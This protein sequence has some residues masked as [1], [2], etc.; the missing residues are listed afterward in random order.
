MRELVGQVDVVADD[1]ELADQ[2]TADV[3]G[4]PQP[5]GDA[6]IDLAKP[7]SLDYLHASE[8]PP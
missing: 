8:N 3:T 5:R 6:P 4:D 7:R 2:R 1:R